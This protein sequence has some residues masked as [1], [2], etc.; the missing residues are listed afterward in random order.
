M[1]RSFGAPELIVIG[2]LV[3]LLFGGSWLGRIGRLAGEKVKQFVLKAKWLWASATGSEKEALEKERAFGRELARQV[4][5]EYPAPVAEA[6][7]ALVERVG[8][9]LCGQRKSPWPFSFRVISAPVANAFALPGGFVFVY[10]PLVDMFSADEDALA[11]V[12]AHEM[13]H[14]LLGHAR[15]AQLRRLL[16]GRISAGAGG[17]G[18]LAEKL[19]ALAYSREDEL[20]ADREA[21]AIMK[22]AGFDTAGA[23]AFFRRSERVEFPALEYF[24][25]HPPARERLRA[26]QA[27]ASTA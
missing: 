7:Q 8:A 13:A 27:Q 24:S 11:F 3:L 20:E 26:V 21:V 23:A 17:I 1:F 14:V 12:L 15:E 6:K 25:T 5:R 18:Q 22:A 9:R 10:E 16:L 4:M 19:L 2:V